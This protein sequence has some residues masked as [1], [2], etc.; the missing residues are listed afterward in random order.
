MVFFGGT[1]EQSWFLGFHLQ[2]NMNPHTKS[3]ILPQRKELSPANFDAMFR[4]TQIHYPL[5]QSQLLT[6]SMVTLW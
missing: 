4:H 5:V 2:V 1:L 3:T 6:L